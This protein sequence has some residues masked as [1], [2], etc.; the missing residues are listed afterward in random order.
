MNRS[1]RVSDFGR[2]VSRKGSC[3]VSGVVSRTEKKPAKYLVNDNNF[4]L[5]GIALATSRAR[6]YCLKESI[7]SREFSSSYIDRAFLKSFECP[8]TEAVPG[9]SVGH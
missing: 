9:N 2:P 4:C 1:I 3:E 5:F 7:F 6:N 8:A